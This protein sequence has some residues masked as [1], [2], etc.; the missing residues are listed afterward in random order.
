MYFMISFQTVINLNY[1]LSIIYNRLQSELMALMVSDV[2]FVFKSHSM[3]FSSLLPHCL[4][5][6]IKISRFDRA[7]VDLLLKFYYRCGSTDEW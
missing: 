1:S 4:C 7:L 6:S 3:W 5:F 2:S